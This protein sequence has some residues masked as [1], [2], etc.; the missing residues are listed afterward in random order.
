MR[1]AWDATIPRG[2]ARVELEATRPLA[3]ARDGGR[4]RRHGE[5]AAIGEAAAGRGGGVMGGVKEVS[6]LSDRKEQQ[7]IWGGKH[8]GGGRRL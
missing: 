3:A 2:L 1:S 4:H 5:R 7:N 8:S 6:F